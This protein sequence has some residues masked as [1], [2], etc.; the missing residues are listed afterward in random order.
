MSI[1]SVTDGVAGYVTKIAESHEDGE[2]KIIYTGVELKGICGKRIVIPNSGS[3]YLTFTNKTPEYIIQQL[4]QTQLIAPQDTK[5]KL[6]SMSFSSFTAGTDTMSKEYRFSDIQEEIIA[7]AET[8]NIGWYADVQNDSS[9]VWHIYHGTDRRQSQSA[10]SRLVLS[11]ENDYLQDSNIEVSNTVPSTALVAGQGEGTERQITMVGDSATGANRT[12][13]YIDARDIKEGENLEQR[14]KEKLA[15]YGTDSVYDASLSHSLL[16]RYRKDFDIGDIATIVDTRLTNGS[17]DII[18]TEIEEVYEETEE[19]KATFGYDKAS[20]ANALKRTTANMDSLIT[21]EPVDALP[22]AG[23]T[24]K[25]AV[26]FK[27]TVSMCN[28]TNYPS[29]AFKASATGGNQII[30]RVAARASLENNAIS[31]SRI[32]FLQYSFKSGS[33]VPSTYYEDYSLPNCTPNLTAHSYYKILTNKNPVTVAQGGTGATSAAAAIANLG[34][35]PKTHTHSM[36]D[37]SGLY[38]GTLRTIKVPADYPTIQAA[39]NSIPKLV[40]AS[41]YI[42]VAAGTYTENLNISGFYGNAIINIRNATDGG[43][44]NLVG[45]ITIN[46][47]GCGIQINAITASTGTI[48]P[49]F[50]IM[51]PDATAAGQS[52]IICYK[53]AYVRLYNLLIRGGNRTSTYYYMGLNADQGSTVYISGCMIQRCY[54]AMRALT[55]ATIFA[56]NNI[57]GQASTVAV[58]NTNLQNTRAMNTSAGLIYLAGKTPSAITNI[59]DTN[60]GETRGTAVPSLSW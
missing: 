40:L 19:I 36:S 3:A 35:A 57:G 13:V 12:E 39:I 60:N 34:A 33:N 30:G 15:E 4:I 6:P 20:L 11:Y 14:G 46:G 51:P 24:V 25:G 2:Y 45:T 1:I 23:G 48:A 16:A 10:N 53:C 47:C 29:I 49:D 54:A 50:R 58:S 41:T 27:N 44:V 59:A 26:N 37:V 42:D 21:V 43:I 56:H 52:V 31:I 28:S 55:G 17:I 8:Y 38:N 18:L 32:Y 5:R 7:L 9:I 22:I